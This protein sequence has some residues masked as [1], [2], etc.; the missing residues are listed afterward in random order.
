MVDQDV[1]LADHAEHVGDVAVFALEA[2]LG[3][4]G[5]GLVPQVRV[6]LE[7]DDVPEVGQVEQSA[8]L[9]DFVLLEA[10]HLDQLFGECRVHRL[11]DL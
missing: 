2:R 11:R 3:D 7:L 10:Q 8:D 6:S 9:E 4:R 5:P 1:A